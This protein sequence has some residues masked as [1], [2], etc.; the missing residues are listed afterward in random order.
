MSMNVVLNESK[1]KVAF[2][3]DTRHLYFSARDTGAKVDYYKLLVYVRGNELRRELVIKNAYIADTK[4]G[5]NKKFSNVLTKIGYNV[6][7]KTTDVINLN[8]SSDWRAE[9]TVHAI[10]DAPEYNTI[11]WGSGD[12]CFVE[13]LSYLKE[14]GKS[15]NILCFKNSFSWKLMDV[16]D[17]V[18]FITD[19]LFLD[20]RVS[21][22]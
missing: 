10:K 1:A 16:V 20:E 19:K 5:K 21:Y 22:E 8:T 12:S 9:M 17:E 11:V 4:D 15:V 18:F 7:S 13:L 6:F 3:V 2:Y 14:L